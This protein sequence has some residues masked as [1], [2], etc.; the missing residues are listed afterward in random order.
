M[1]KR[2]LH[3]RGDAGSSP[4]KSGRV[5]PENRASSDSFKTITHN[6]DKTLIHYTKIYIY[7]H[8][9]LVQVELY[10]WMVMWLNTESESVSMC[11]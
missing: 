4:N 1:V 8:N 9:Y 5:N 10:K 3:F 7:F 2:S 6:L 11:L